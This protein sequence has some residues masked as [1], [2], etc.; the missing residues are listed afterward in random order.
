MVFDEIIRRI[1]KSPIPLE[2]MANE[3][4]RMAEEKRSRK[5]KGAMLSLN[6][7]LGLSSFSFPI[8]AM[9]NRVRDVCQREMKLTITPKT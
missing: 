5:A 1:P 8:R 7:Q 3:E 2:K 4:I 6:I 9:K